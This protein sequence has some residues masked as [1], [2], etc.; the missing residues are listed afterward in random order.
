MR[1][2]KAIP[3]TMISLALAAG[4]CASSSPSPAQQRVERAETTT[5]VLD[6]HRPTVTQVEARLMVG[7]PGA[8]GLTPAEIEQVRAFANDYLRLG[9]GNVVLSVPNGSANQG[10]AFQVAQDV[11]RLMFAIGVDFSRMSGGA[12]QATG[13]GH[14]P[15]VLSFARYEARAAECTPWSEMD[16]R[17]TASNLASERFGCAQN[18]NLAAMVVD[19]G[20]LAGDRREE[21]RDAQRMQVGIE[22]HRQGSLEK[23]S[24]SVGGQ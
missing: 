4:S 7:T 18:A 19:P 13:Q 14:A 23:S 1:T 3:L 17:K 15:V 2:Q 24:G 11:Q 5:T 6:A 12:Y 16:P 9:R 10:A 21:P 22:A 8:P 20:D